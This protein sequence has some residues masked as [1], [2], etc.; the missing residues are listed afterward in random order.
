MQSSLQGFF[1]LRLSEAMYMR[2]ES[3]DIRPGHWREVELGASSVVHILFNPMSE[4]RARAALPLR[5]VEGAGECAE[6]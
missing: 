1:G 4:V 3:S 6:G 2:S 5:G